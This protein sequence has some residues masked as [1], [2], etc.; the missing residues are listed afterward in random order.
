MCIITNKQNGKSNDFNSELPRLPR[1]RSVT[2]AC[3]DDSGVFQ[4]ISKK[5]VDLRNVN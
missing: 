1:L 2:V 4:S 3:N 5:L